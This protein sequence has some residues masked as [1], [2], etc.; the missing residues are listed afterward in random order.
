MIEYHK[1][2]K[3]VIWVSPEASGV[4]RV[5]SRNVTTHLGLAAVL[6]GLSQL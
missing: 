5:V 2:P 4:G 3:K 6:A 1:R